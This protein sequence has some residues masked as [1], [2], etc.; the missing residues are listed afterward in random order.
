MTAEFYD[1]ALDEFA[2]SRDV[3]NLVVSA[4]DGVRDAA[5]S[6]APVLTGEYRDS[7]HVE[8]DQDRAG[9]VATVVA[10]VEYAMVV[11]SREGVL[12]RALNKVASRA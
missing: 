12:A 10:D 11:E 8:V 4:A 2:S 5:R 1:S 3:R 9:V 7:I 6:G